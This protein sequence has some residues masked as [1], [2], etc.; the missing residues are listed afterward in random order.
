MGQ[1]I[2]IDSATMMNKGLEVI[3][4][5]WLFDVSLDDIQILVHP[6]SIVHSAVEFSDTSVIAQLG[7]PDMKIPISIAFAYPDRLKFDQPGLNFF[8]EGSNLTFEEPDTEVFG[9]IKLAYEASRKGG[10]YPVVMN[11]ANEVLVDMFLK[12]K[13]TFVEIEKNIEKILNNHNPTYNLGLN[14]IIE[15]DNEIREKVREEIKG[16]L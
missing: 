4:A 2:T 8:R 9:C 13:I 16:D 12:E 10:S 3:E 7:L 6:Q 14:D 11:A 5:K 1:K 15:I